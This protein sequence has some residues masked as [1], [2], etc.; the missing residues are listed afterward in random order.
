MRTRA[1]VAFSGL[2]FGMCS[3]AHA[4]APGKPLMA[5]RELAA[6]WSCMERTVI[7][8]ADR[9]ATPERFKMAVEGACLTEQ[10]AALDA[11]EAFLRQG[12]EGYAQITMRTVGKLNDTLQQERAKL[13]SSYVVAYETHV[14]KG[15]ER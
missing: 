8:M 5:E 3:G 10:Q 13:V 4:Q 2:V 1:V 6:W 11:A 12:D 9:R 15:E 14:P 7:P